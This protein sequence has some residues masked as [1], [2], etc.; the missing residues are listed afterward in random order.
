MQYNSMNDQKSSKLLYFLL[1]VNLIFTIIICFSG[2]YCY[3]RYSNM[4]DT[5]IQIT[6][7]YTEHSNQIKN[8]I[9][10]VQQ[11]NETFDNLNNYINQGK[12]MFDYL[13]T[14]NET[15]QLMNYY[16]DTGVHMLEFY[17]RYN[18]TSLF[19]LVFDIYTNKPHYIS[20][21]LN[22]LETLENE[23]IHKIVL[24]AIYLINSSCKILS[25]P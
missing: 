19:D 21:I 9:N 23:N 8:I 20:I 13:E 7:I 15:I 1:F 16:T 6:N 14:R 17:N 2:L 24:D 4:F 12:R 25:C 10:F 5:G 22:V 3:L 18:F 11:R